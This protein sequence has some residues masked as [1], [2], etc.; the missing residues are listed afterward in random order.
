MK[1]TKIDK[2]GN[3]TGNECPH[4][5]PL[6]NHHDGCPSCYTSSNKC[7]VC[8]GEGMDF[9]DYTNARGGSVQ[10]ETCGLCDGNGIAIK[11]KDYRI[12]AV[13]DSYGNAGIDYKKLT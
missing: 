5:D 9:L 8:D 12:V 11:D 7:P 1:Y 3:I 10:F 2:Q 6:H 13:S 4:N